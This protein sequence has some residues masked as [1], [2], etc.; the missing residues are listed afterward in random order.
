[1]V[2]GLRMGYGKGVAVV[3]EDYM[4]GLITGNGM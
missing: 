4:T 3:G 2:L 1:L